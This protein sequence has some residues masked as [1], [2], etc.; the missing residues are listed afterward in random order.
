MKQ[1]AKFYFFKYKWYTVI[2]A[3]AILFSLLL[4]KIVECGLYFVGYISLRYMFPKT[5]HHS[6][7]YCCIFWSIMMMVSAIYS[8]MSIN[9]SLISS[10][11]LSFLV[12]YILYRVQDYIDMKNIINDEM[13]LRQRCE[14]LMLSNTMTE[15]A[16]DYLIN[17]LSAKEQAEK[18][19]YS[20][21]TIKNY[22][23]TIKKKLKSYQ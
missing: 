1:T 5:F 16:V 8:V 6:K 19:G 2:F 14:K 3:C 15:I 20:V 4:G 23:S 10:V 18:M 9:I 13:I 11:L 12:G 21:Q 22:R 17:R 7:F